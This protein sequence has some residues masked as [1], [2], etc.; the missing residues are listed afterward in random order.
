MQVPIKVKMGSE[1]VR[2]TDDGKV[3]VN[4]ALRLM[5]RESES[6]TLWERVKKD[7][8]SILEYCEDIPVSDDETTTITN[9][10][11]WGLIMNVLQQ[12]LFDD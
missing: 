7:H 4:D 8:P 12:Y 3:F 6:H 11:G 10:K 1:S 9:T 2:F 5:T